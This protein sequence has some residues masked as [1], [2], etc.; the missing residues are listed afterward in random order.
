MERLIVGRNAFL[1]GGINGVARNTRLAIGLAHGVQGFHIDDVAHIAAELVDLAA[2]NREVAVAFVTGIPYAGNKA[3]LLCRSDRVAVPGRTRFEM[4]LQIVAGEGTKTLDRT[5]LANHDRDALVVETGLES[6][7]QVVDGLFGTERRAGA[8][9]RS[10]VTRSLVFPVIEHLAPVLVTAGHERELVG[11]KVDFGHGVAGARRVFG[12]HRRKERSLFDFST[13]SL[14]DHDTGSVVST[15]RAHRLEACFMIALEH[16]H[17][18]FVKCPLAIVGPAVPRIVHTRLVSRCKNQMF[19]IFGKLG[20]NL[21]PVVFLLCRNLCCN[22]GRFAALVKALA[23]KH[24]VFEPATIPVT[25]QNGVHAITNHEIDNRLDGVKPARVDGAIGGMS[26]PCA[27]D[28]DGI[29]TRILD[30]LYVGCI[31]ERVAPSCGTTL[32]ARNFH[33]IADVVAE[34]HLGI[35]FDRFRETLRVRKHRKGKGRQNHRTTG[36]VI[37][38]HS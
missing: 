15:G 4:R 34:A 33:R 11:V 23:V 14:H 13:R 2:D 5:H 27:R 3:V 21:L 17:T 19:V 30:S 8:S 31:R 16:L 1:D 36:D 25:I 37:V 32:V 6:A 24:V 28:A 38:F 10:I 12:V 22:N 9:M 35:D 18:S 29:E 20:R 7:K 26:I